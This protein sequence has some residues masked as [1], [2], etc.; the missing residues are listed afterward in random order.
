[1]A[2]A[3]PSVLLIAALLA[4]PA[5]ASCVNGETPIG[6]AALRYLICVPV[7]AIMLAILRA[8]TRDYGSGPEPIIAH[9]LRRRT[10]PQ[11]DRPIEGEAPV[12]PREPQP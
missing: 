12:K 2:I 7:A 8:L 9:M 11:P 6:D 3:S 1:V 4:S 10:D 5:I